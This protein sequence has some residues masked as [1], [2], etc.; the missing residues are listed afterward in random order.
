MDISE[1]SRNPLEEFPNSSEDNA[2]VYK[3]WQLH[4]NSTRTFHFSKLLCDI[5]KHTFFYSFSIMFSIKVVLHYMDAVSSSTITGEY[6]FH[7]V[8][9]FNLSFTRYQLSSTSY[10]INSTITNNLT[11][12]LTITS[13]SVYNL[14]SSMQEIYNSYSE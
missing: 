4:T 5:G 9:P 2:S 8:K 12:P 13:V 6:S 11:K 7:S 1:R 3:P 10:L 14:I